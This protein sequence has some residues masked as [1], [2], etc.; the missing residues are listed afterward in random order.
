M[1]FQYLIPI[2]C[3]LWVRIETKFEDNSIFSYNFCFLNF[4]GAYVRLTTKGTIMV[5]GVLASCYAD[6]NH[7]LVHFTIIP[8][9]KFSEVMEWIFGNEFGFPL[10]VATARELGQLMLP[11][12]QYWSY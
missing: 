7:D 12:G 8:M 6:F 11:Y 2:Y 9:Q 5:D 10:Y 4:E 3:K 1:Y